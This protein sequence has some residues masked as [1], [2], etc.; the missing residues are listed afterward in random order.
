MEKLS[1]VFPDHF[2]FE[3]FAV[4]LPQIV[5]FLQI[6]PR[7]HS[8]HISDVLDCFF[9]NLQLV[10]PVHFSEISIVISDLFL[11]MIVSDHVFVNFAN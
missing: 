7:D 3:K 4:N 11:Q 8:L 1:I 5:L 6:L 2:S 10:V 9:E